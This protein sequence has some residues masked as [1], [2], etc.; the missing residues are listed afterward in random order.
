[1]TYG[2]NLAAIQY[3]AA[4]YVDRILK[5]TNTGDL[6]IEQPTAFE[7]A[8]DLKTAAALGLAMPAT[9]ALQVTGGCNEV[10]HSAMRGQAGSMKSFQASPRLYN[11][12]ARR[13]LCRQ[14]GRVG[15]GG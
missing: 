14:A 11:R 13:D 15:A 1:M 3:R 6:P 7:L 9:V 8:V 2:P 5:G 4:S 12:L 10:T